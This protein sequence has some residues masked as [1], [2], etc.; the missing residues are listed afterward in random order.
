M[1]TSGV[2]FERRKYCGKYVTP[3]LDGRT[4]QFWTATKQCE[5]GGWRVHGGGCADENRFYTT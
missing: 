3:L 4:G 1:A 5:R 2:Y